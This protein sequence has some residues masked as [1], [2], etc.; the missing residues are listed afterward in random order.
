MTWEAPSSLMLLQDME[1]FNI[2]LHTLV[3]PSRITQRERIEEQILA[4]SEL[5][6]ASLFG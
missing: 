5:T 1:N 4:C 6:V 3:Y 2:Y